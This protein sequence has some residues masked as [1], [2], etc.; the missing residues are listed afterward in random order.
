MTDD[1]LKAAIAEIPYWYHKIPL[2]DAITTPGWAPLD[3]QA[4]QIPDDLTG[5]RVLD[6]G[7]WDGFWAFEALR[8]GAKFV[9]AI[10]DFSDTCG[11]ATNANRN[12]EWKTLDLCAKALGYGRG[13]LN[14]YECSVYEVEEVVDVVFCF[15]VLYHL[16]DPM[17]AL[18]RL[19]GCL[20]RGG[21][22][23]IETAIL[24]RCKSV[25]SDYVYT[26]DECVA[27]FYPND[28][29]GMNHSN[30]WVG[31]LKF[32]A[33]LVQATGFQNIEYWKL[34]DAPQ[35]VAQCRG[36]IRASVGA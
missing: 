23:H 32:W 11:K 18:R 9:I 5:K 33:N 12:E 26:G 27:E 28:E 30:W 20:H 31:T 25:Y 8:R 4:Y 24:D 35:N 17:R 22:I 36:F 3:V 7:A 16:I 29:Y 2:R 19:R 15:G 21:T 13:H 6:V 14:C 10:D 1:E 34:T